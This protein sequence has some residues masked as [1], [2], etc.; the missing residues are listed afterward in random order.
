MCLDLVWCTRFLSIRWAIGLLHIM[1]GVS[2]MPSLNSNFNDEIHVS[3]VGPFTNYALVKDLEMT[4][5][6]AAFHEMRLPLRKTYCPPTLLISSWQL[7]Q[8]A[9][10]LKRRSNWVGLVRRFH[11]HECPSNILVCFATHQCKS[12]GAAMN[13]SS[14]FIEKVYIWSCH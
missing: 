13:W 6:L 1:G 9:L 3:S 14:L 10:V 5:C 12:I 8:L 4:L 2:T 11:D 7:S